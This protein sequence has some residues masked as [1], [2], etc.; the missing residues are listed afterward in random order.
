[1]YGLSPLD[2]SVSVCKTK[3]IIYFYVFHTIYYTH[4]LKEQQIPTKHSLNYIICIFNYGFNILFVVNIL[5]FTVIGIKLGN[6]NLSCRH[7]CEFI[8]FPQSY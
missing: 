2:V 7:V 3:Y 5:I 6:V 4:I 1:M 8:Y